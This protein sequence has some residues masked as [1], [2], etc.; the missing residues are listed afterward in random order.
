MTDPLSSPLSLIPAHAFV[1]ANQGKF[2]SKLDFADRCSVLAFVKAGVQ[3]NLIAKT[4]AVDRRTVS[5]IVNP[6]SPHYKDVRKKYE[7]LGPE[8]FKLE[9]I[10]EAWSLKVA[11][12]ASLPAPASAPVPTGGQRAPNA[13]AARFKGVHVINGTRVEI[14]YVPDSDDFGWR[15]RELDGSHP[16]TWL[17]NGEESRMTSQ[18][19]YKAL[20][21]NL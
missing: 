14:G 20:E 17:H 18:A 12:S 13:R 21:E 3:R 10:T 2:Q 7:E 15:Y 19:C 5:H 8:Q 6:A 1:K 4:F 11:E 9:Y 16:E